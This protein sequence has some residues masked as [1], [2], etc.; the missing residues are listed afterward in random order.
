LSFGTSSGKLKQVRRQIQ[1]ITG[2][3]DFSYF[4]LKFV[5]ALF[6]PATLIK[7]AAKLSTTI[8]SAVWNYLATDTALYA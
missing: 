6:T 8:M 3:F 1:Q 5:S 4:L 2:A 7:P